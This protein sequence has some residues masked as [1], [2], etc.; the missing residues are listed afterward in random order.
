M[1]L[2]LNNRVVAMFLV[3]F[4]LSSI[5]ISLPTISL[6]A[7]EP[8][9][10]GVS[11]VN[12]TQLKL[13]FSEPVWNK[14]VANDNSDIE[15]RRG[16]GGE[17]LNIQLIENVPNGS[18]KVG[19]II[20]ILDPL[21]G[22][23]IPTVEII[24][25]SNIILDS[26]DTTTAD[27]GDV[28][29][30]NTSI[31]DAALLAINTAT[32]STG[33]KNALE[34]NADVFG[35]DISDGS[36]YED[37]ESG[38]IVGAYVLDSNDYDYANIKSV[39][40]AFNNA[41]TNLQTIDEINDADDADEVREIIEDSYNRK[42]LSLSMTSYN[43]LKDAGKYAVAIAVYNGGTDYDDGDIVDDI[44]AIKDKFDTAVT[45]NKS[46]DDMG[47]TS[48][49]NESN[50]TV[51]S[52]I[53]QYTSEGDSKQLISYLNTN[54]DKLASEDI[55]K[56][57]L[58]AADIILERTSKLNTSDELSTVQGKDGTVIMPEEYRL[59]SAID[60]TVTLVDNFK[61]LFE[62]GNLGAE[63]G[64]L[65]KEI[66][67]YLVASIYSD[68][69]FSVSLPIS[70]LIKSKEKLVGVVIQQR[71][72]KLTFPSE[73][74][75][76]NSE[77]GTVTNV[78]ISANKVKGDINI[79]EGMSVVGSVYEFDAQKVIQSNISALGT[80]EKLNKFDKAITIEMSYDKV[81]TSRIKDINKIGVYI[82]D[83][84]KGKWIRIKAIIDTENK[85][86]IFETTHFSKYA[87]IEYNKSFD[88]VGEEHWAKEYIEAL[89][90][91]QITQGI[92]ENSFEPSGKVS[93]AQF[94]TFLVRG[95]GLTIGE[96]QGKFAD[97]SS[98]DWYAGTVEAAVDASLVEGVGN[99]KFAPNNQITREEMAVMIMRA[100]KKEKDINIS[101][102]ADKAAG[103]FED[104]SKMSDWA[105]DSILAAKANGI[106]SGYTDSLF[107]PKLPA[108]RAQA[109][110]MIM[111]LLKKVE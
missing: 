91:K 26:D 53:R 69:N 93:R 43:N 66:S 51:I 11:V 30:S 79:E 58:K 73:A 34:S 44:K 33:A 80:K 75:N 7:D 72:V 95:L 16:A 110:K 2:I 39:T 67:I 94:A 70:T 41:L 86:I 56:E 88:D 38:K 68:R 96:Y 65:K 45:A 89:A 108:E 109:A 17:I 100:Y 105:R 18:G 46:N 101:N 36:D 42:A 90:T 62:T 61:T 20:T 55:K 81:D 22:T 64:K 63:A 8:E 27:E 5:F 83:E 3:V 13:M 106:I 14:G 92:T 1:G 102:E 77:S 4:F 59:N 111:E 23:D 19:W 50:K 57:V 103:I 6:A 104:A 25:G 29:L 98:D 85:K 15:I 9:L 47:S 60:K 10:Q 21:I 24:D 84:E 97:V 28:I 32:T 76:T 71:D 99:G 49:T 87:I 40:D 82:Y 31:E 12:S 52:K 74:I 54:K 35:I 107:A 78:E 48:T 37:L